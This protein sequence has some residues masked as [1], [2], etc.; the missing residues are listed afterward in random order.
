MKRRFADADIEAA[1]SLGRHSALKREWRGRA[2]WAVRVAGDKARRQMATVGS[3]RGMI[4]RV[5][6]WRGK[7]EGERQ[8]RYEMLWRALQ[9][10][11]AGGEG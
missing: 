8:N 11:A 5:A 7:R 6:Y 10:P 1:F 4:C 2:P 3:V 9:A